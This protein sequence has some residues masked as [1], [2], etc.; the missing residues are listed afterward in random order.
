[1]YGLPREFSPSAIRE[2][3]ELLTPQ[4]VRVLW[5]SKAHGGG[6][7]DGAAAA[8]DAAAAPPPAEADSTRTGKETAEAQ[9]ELLTEPV[10]GTRYD[11]SP[12]PSDWMAAWA[13]AQPEDSPE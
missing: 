2:A 8:P 9:E 5:S 7:D 11:I 6:D 12:L 13:A 4:R 10:Y 3:L 1:M